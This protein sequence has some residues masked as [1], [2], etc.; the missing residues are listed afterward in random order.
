MLQRIFLLILVGVTLISCS[1]ANT[2]SAASWDAQMGTTSWQLM[3]LGETSV[4]D[5]AVTLELIR[6]DQGGL[7]F[8]GQGFCNNYSTQITINSTDNTVTVGSVASTRRMCPDPQMNNE[9]DYFAAL[10]ATTRISLVDSKLIFASAQG[11]ALLT[12]AK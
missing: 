1:S 5:D 7:S 11:Q 8:N 12:F 6:D 4:A 9:R 2:P 3:Q 10:E